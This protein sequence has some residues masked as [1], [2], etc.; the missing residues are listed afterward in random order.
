MSVLD[1]TLNNQMVSNA[2]DLENAEYL[3]IAITPRSTVAR[4]G[5]NW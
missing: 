2:E 5:S 4:S 1:M 3:L